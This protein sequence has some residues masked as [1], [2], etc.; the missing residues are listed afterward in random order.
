MQRWEDV[1]AKGEPKCLHTFC[2]LDLK[3]H[4][5]RSFHFNASVS[6]Y[7]LVISSQLSYWHLLLGERAVCCSF[8]PAASWPSSS[9]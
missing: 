8:T 7:A 2:R 6:L 5:H 3:E 4:L 9:S 1:D